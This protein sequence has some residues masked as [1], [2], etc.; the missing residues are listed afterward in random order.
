M[1]FFSKEEK[2]RNEAQYY[3][4]FPI[5]MPCWCPRCRERTIRE[6]IHEELHSIKKR[7]RKKK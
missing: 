5:F 7:G 1:G 2:C 6:I 4:F 3:S